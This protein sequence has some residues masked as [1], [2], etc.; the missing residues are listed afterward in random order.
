MGARRIFAA[1]IA[2]VMLFS[3]AL[4]EVKWSV[5]PPTGEAEVPFDGAVYTAKGRLIAQIGDA[6]D[7][8]GPPAQQSYEF[9]LSVREAADGWEA[10]LLLDTLLAD[11]GEE[12]WLSNRVEIS[13]SIGAAGGN[14]LVKDT[15]FDSLGNPS[16]EQRY[17][18]T[19]DGDYRLVVRDEVTG[20]VIMDS[21]SG[22]IVNP[23]AVAANFAAWV[24]ANPELEQSV[25]EA[26][27]PL[28]RKLQGFLFDNADSAIVHMRELV[29]PV[30]QLFNDPRMESAIEALGVPGLSIPRMSLLE[31]L[32]AANGVFELRRLEKGDVSVTYC[33]Q[34]SP[35]TSAFKLEAVIYPTG[36]DFKVFRIAF[37]G[38][39]Y[40]GLYDTVGAGEIDF[41]D[42]LHFV[43]EDYGFGA[44]LYV[45][46][47]PGEMSAN[48]QVLDARA[49]YKLETYD[50]PALLLLHFENAI[51]EDAGTSRTDG[52]LRLVEGYSTATITLEIDHT[53]KE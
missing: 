51:D 49:A 36:L 8:Y 42:G 26:F 4:A 32:A 5:A 16:S 29:L 15:S 23:S 11:T 14:C 27:G 44:F 53:F 35:M 34:G 1:L 43:V 40:D 21:G 39:S 7:A 18:A 13:L 38:A 20:N 17:S 46:A 45:D 48:R 33:S 52:T 50:D 41:S 2:V 30:V 28:M 12:P 25:R 31:L 19:L 47:S 22:Q 10:E 24:W 6:N 37:D 3:G 9:E